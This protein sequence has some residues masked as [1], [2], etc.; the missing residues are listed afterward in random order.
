M[1]ISLKHTPHAT[2]AA[3]REQV[4]RG[5]LRLEIPAARDAH[6]VRDGLRGAERPAAAAVRLVA[7]V[8]DAR[9]R[10]PLGT[11]VELLRQRVHVDVRVL[12]HWESRAAVPHAHEA[13][14]LPLRP[15]DE[16]RRRLRSEHEKSLITY[17]L[18]VRSY[19][20]S[21]YVRV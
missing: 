8:A 3:A 13:L 16:L 14:Q 19:S 4:V 11:R 17:E 2:R 9:A 6:A 1:L 18:W 5:Q 20:V 15:A 7:D 10:G 12:E 21:Y